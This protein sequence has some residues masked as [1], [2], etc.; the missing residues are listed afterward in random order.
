MKMSIY[1]LKC[2]NTL[3]SLLLVGILSIQAQDTIPFVHLTQSLNKALIDQNQ[4]QLNALLHPNLTYGHSNGWIESKEE[5]IQNNKSKYLVYEKISMD[6]LR[7][8]TYNDVS[9]VR[10][11]STIDVN[12]NGKSINLKLHVC[13]TWVQSEGSWTLLARQSTKIN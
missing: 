9:I 2:L 3:L 12:L 6:S 13:Q 10:Y 11:D 5:L 4:D 7:I 1:K 8:K